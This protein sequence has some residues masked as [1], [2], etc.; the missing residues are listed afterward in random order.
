MAD[1]IQ[2]R[3]DTKA[4]WASFNPILLEGEVGYELDTDQYKVGDGVHAWNSLPYRGDPC[5]NQLG[6]STTTPISQ[7]VSTEEIRKRK[8]GFFASEAR[9][10]KQNFDGIIDIWVESGTLPEDVDLWLWFLAQTGMNDIYTQTLY[11]MPTDSEL[12]PDGNPWSATTSNKILNSYNAGGT[13][14]NPSPV[15]KDFQ[16]II[17]TLYGSNP[18]PGFRL[19]FAIDWS[20]VTDPVFAT[21]RYAKLDKAAILEST[22]RRKAI[23]EQNTAIANVK[24]RAVSREQ[25]FVNNTI[26]SL[27]GNSNAHAVLNIVPK[28]DPRKMYRYG[29]GLW[30]L[31]NGNGTSTTPSVYIVKC[32]SDGSLDKSGQGIVAIWQPDPDGPTP[33]GP[34]T[35]IQTV[36]VK[37]NVDP[38]KYPYGYGV[39]EFD[40]TID[41]DKVTTVDASS[42]FDLRFN[43]DFFAQFFDNNPIPNNGGKMSVFPSSG[44]LYDPNNPSPSFILSKKGDYGINLEMT[45]KY[46]DLTW[47]NGN[48]WSTTSDASTQ[49][50]EANSLMGWSNPIAIPE[51]ITKIKVVSIPSGGVCHAFLD[52]SGVPVQRF[53]T[54]GTGWATPEYLEYDVPERAVSI[55]FSWTNASFGYTD[56][57]KAFVGEN[58]KTYGN[59]DTLPWLKK[60]GSW[61][62]RQQQFVQGSTFRTTDLIEIG[63]VKVISAPKVP[64]ADF[65]MAFFDKNKKLMKV[66]KGYTASGSGWETLM[67][68]W[69]VPPGAVYFSHA[70][71]ETWKNRFVI[72]EG[73]WKFFTLTEDKQNL[74]VWN[75]NGKQNINDPYDNNGIFDLQPINVESEEPIVELMLFEVTKNLPA[76]PPQLFL[77]SDK[78]V[79]LYKNSLFTKFDNLFN[80]NVN[81]KSTDAA[82]NG[83]RIME[84]IEPTYF[85]PEDFADS[86]QIFLQRTSDYSKLFFKNIKVLAKDIA[87]VSGKTVSVLSLGDSLTE[88]LEWKNTPVT[89][90]AT[91]LEKLN[92]T[93]KFIGTLA[94]NFVNPNGNVTTKINYEGHGGWRYRTMIGLESQFAGLNIIIPNATRSEWFYPTDGTMNQIK[95]NNPFLYPATDSDKANNPN[96]CFHFVTGNTVY[97]QSYAENPNLGDY[98]IFDPVRY[99][100]KRSIEIP[101]VVT[102]AFGTNE[103]YLDVYGGFDLD[104]ATS[105]AEFI[106]KQFRKVS[107]TMN[108]VVI[109]L[110]N[111][112]TTRQQAWETAALPLCANVMR[113]VE[114]MINSGDNHTF[115]CPIYA[116]G[117]RWLAYNDFVGAASD[118]SATNSLKQR[119]MDANV[120]MLYVD[121]DSNKDYADSLTAC[122]VNLIE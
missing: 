94:R 74:A 65:G 70:W 67:G 84:V 97:N 19:G 120:H 20:K 83:R 58:F 53:G 25:Y 39:L 80:V 5:L 24:Q 112:P 108:I 63:D 99:F 45:L 117:S 27:A 79:P 60:G 106:F 102:I 35:G 93:T 66:V 13:S 121:D 98:V 31:T 105:A 21:T 9:E 71:W 7:K 96:F 88:G 59:W 17:T 89:M 47:N 77:R 110:N 75:P 92:V 87:S 28:V 43:D 91:E 10:I 111:L 4:R 90:L 48:V 113:V 30:Y 118:V 34:M 57:F 114:N 15:R 104:K 72:K 54:K 1:R 12:D 64:G 16:N 49:Y 119:T 32:N 109:P 14:T 61:S 50:K 33:H 11:V 107:P 8:S 82:A 101:D 103:W 36:T 76:V 51:G 22:A 42:R 86:G 115:V 78:A 23:A 100:S 37:G 46:A 85:K 6:N 81:I 41:W 116:Q 38:D 95:A 56:V 68:A 18:D 44:D 26:G 73:K 62:V 40:I 69:I 2:Q 3:R 52:A 122:V 29:I 55:S